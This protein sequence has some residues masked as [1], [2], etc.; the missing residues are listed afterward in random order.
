MLVYDA[1]LEIWTNKK[2]RKKKLA[3]QVK[4]SKHFQISIFGSS[5][6]AKNR[7][8]SLKVCNF[9]LHIIYNNI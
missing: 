1:K 7:K 5:K 9:I 8:G 4:D 2:K 3:S 6:L